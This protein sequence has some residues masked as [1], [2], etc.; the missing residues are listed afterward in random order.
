MATAVRIGHPPAPSPPACPHGDGPL[1]TTRIDRWW[2][3]PLGNAL[4]LGVLS[5][6]AVWAG[7][8]TSD[9]ATAHYISPLYSPCVAADCGRHATVVLVGRWWRWS[10]A[11]LVMAVPIGVRATCYY[12]R[13]LYYRSFW[14][15]PPACA[16]AEPR[17]R[18][19][20]ESRL[21]LV[22]QNAHRYFWAAS[23]LV[24]LMLTAD[25]VRS[26]GQ[27]RGVGIGVG[28][29]LIALTTA[30]FWAYLLSCHACRHL[31]GGGLRAMA[32]HPARRRLWGWVS[33]LNHYHGVFALVSLPLVMVTDAYIRLVASGVWHDPHAVIFG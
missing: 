20:G 23:V 26:F 29:V 21:P 6:Y 25:T 1:A 28:T 10:P 14:L 24:A 7:F 5:A 27:G 22:L 18:D 11:L 33:S 31:V 8:Q 17:R 12:Y 16:V 13:K 4:F 19:V 3:A 32:G 9:F 30:A 15:S 2:L